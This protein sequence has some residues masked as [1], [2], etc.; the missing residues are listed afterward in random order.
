ME[1]NDRGGSTALEADWN[2]VKSGHLE[3]SYGFLPSWPQKSHDKEEIIFKGMI[4]ELLRLSKLFSP[5]V[6]PLLT[7]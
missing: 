3:V 5:R 1:K 4:Y 2:L 7:R 6:P